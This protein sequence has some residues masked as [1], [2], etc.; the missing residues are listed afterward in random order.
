MLDYILFGLIAF[1]LVISLFGTLA[2]P[3]VLIYEWIDECKQ[4]QVWQLRSKLLFWSIKYFCI[5]AGA[6]TVLLVFLIWIGERTHIVMSNF[7]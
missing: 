4:T 5:L 7:L 6:S 1:S 2:V 3:A